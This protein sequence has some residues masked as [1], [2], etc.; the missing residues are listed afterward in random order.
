MVR[1]NCERQGEASE[2]DEAVDAYGDLTES[3]L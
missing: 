1:R 3:T 2:G